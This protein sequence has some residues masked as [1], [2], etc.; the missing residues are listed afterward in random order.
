MARIRDLWF[1][2]VKGPDGKPVKTKT[3]RHPDKGGSKDAKRWLAVWVGPDGKEKSAA[4][5]IRDKAVKYAR[6]MEEDAQRG[7]YIDPDA[8]KALFGPLALKWLRLRDVG[9]G[10]IRRYDSAYRLHLKVPFGDRQIKSIKPSEVLEWLRDLSK[11][12]GHSTQQ[13]AYIILCGVFDL[14]VADGMRRDNPA[15]SSIIPKPTREPHERASWSVDRVWAVIDAHAEPYR[16]IPILGAGCGTRQ[17]ET[18]AFAEEDFDFENGKVYVRRQVVRVGRLLVFKLPKGGK[19]RIA[20]L[21]VGVARAVKAHIDAY[22]P[23]PYSLPWMQEKSAGLAAEEYTCNLL[24][25]WQGDHPRRHEGHMRESSY[26][27]NVCKPA[28]AAASIIPPAAK[29]SRGR[30]RYVAA[31][32]D[33]FHMLRHYLT[34][35]LLDAGVSLAGIMAFLGHS[36]RG[37]PVT[38]GV[39]GHV[40]EETFEAAR[41]AVDQSLFRLRLVPDREADGTG[42][43]QSGSR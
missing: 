29:N 31:N 16:A 27:S 36:R 13:I 18:F 14:A 42:T 1:R 3:I 8:G 17:S 15:K 22:P 33:G 40:T 28:L 35:V 23:R 11:T 41:T 9:S 38:L 43:E 7:E 4:F 25:R 2:P 21:P 12:H 32:D 19:E 24:F 10:S 6:K 5:K 20:P 37:K 34:S 39:Y 26:N 30:M